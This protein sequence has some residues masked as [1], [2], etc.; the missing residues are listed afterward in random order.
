MKL[1]YYLNG[2]GVGVLFATILLAFSFAIHSNKNT[3]MTDT[4]I[5]ARAKELGM[6]MPTQPRQTET[7]P[8]E[9]TSV[10]EETTVPE[11]TS[12]PETTSIEGTS[13]LETT[14]S[15]ENQTIENVTGQVLET[16][17][18]SGITEGTKIVIEINS[19]MTSEDVAKRLAEV[20]V[21]EDYNELNQYLLQEGVA[22]LI[23]IGAY[24]F[25]KGMSFE[26]IKYTICKLKK[27]E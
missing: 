14:I 1:K 20:G 16:S 9:T 15:E 10:I 5:I 3:G 8:E 25:T 17:I 11:E 24:E 4:E 18:D 26:E 2:F 21:V 27:E 7:I 12:A 6:E 23:Q 22:K 19:G 13:S